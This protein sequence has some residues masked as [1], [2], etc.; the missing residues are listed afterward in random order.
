MREVYV[1]T[2]LNGKCKSN[3]HH[4]PFVEIPR[5]LEHLVTEDRPWILCGCNA[6]WEPLETLCEKMW[7]QDPHRG[8]WFELR[9]WP[10]RSQRTRI[11]KLR[12]RVTDPEEEP[13]PGRA[14][15]TESGS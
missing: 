9:E 7:S 8:I 11:V 5:M 1:R 3:P 4:R 15:R 10:F 12:R 6:C 13:R 2:D 14:P